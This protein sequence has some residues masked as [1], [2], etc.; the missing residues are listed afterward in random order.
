MGQDK[1]I[2]QKAIGRSYT[3]FNSFLAITDPAVYFLKKIVTP[4]FDL[5]RVTDPS[6]N[7]I[8]QQAVTPVTGTTV[9]NLTP[10]AGYDHYY[11]GLSLSLTTSRTASIFI[12]GGPYVHENVSG[13]VNLLITRQTGVYVP[14]GF[15]LRI[16]IASTDATDGAI[17]LG[18]ARVQRLAGL[19]PLAV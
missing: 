18:I 13:N 10:P 12:V 3:F 11:L 7:Q 4:V 2:F 6:E 8:F 14:D 16:S 1:N 5:T 19:G 15:T 9:V 17:S